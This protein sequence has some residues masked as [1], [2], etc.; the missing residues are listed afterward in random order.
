MSADP[1]K[2]LHLIWPWIPAFRVVAETEHL[3]TA[4]SRLH[5]SAS[6][7]SRSVKLVEETLGEELF[8]RGSRRI[9]LNAAGQRL[10]AAI[11]RSMTSLEHAMHGVLARDFSGDYR[12]ASLGVLTD[13]FVL[14][15]LLELESEKPGVVPCMTTLKSKE[16]NQQLANGQIEVAFYYDAT[17]MPGIECRRIGTLTNSLYCGKGHPLFEVKGVTL[18]DLAP[19]AQSIAGIGD[20]GTPMDGWPVEIPRKV[21]FQIMMLSTNHQVALS[22]RFVCVL[23]DVV[24]HGDFQ[25]GR[26]W[27]LDPAPVPDTTVYAACRAEDASASFT[28]E[29]IARVER[30]LDAAPRAERPATP[31]PEPR[32]RRSSA[33]RA[34]SKEKPRAK[35]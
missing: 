23:P 11:R 32:A 27:R 7:L 12:V 21:S 31:G 16:A 29:L 25:S 9:T 4:A 6:A 14:P 26:L 35:R 15:A 5:V 30:A 22:G 24:A 17:S 19:H 3:P 20:R 10:L 1:A 13:Y 34:K 28:A 33:G 2:K 8:V 18:E